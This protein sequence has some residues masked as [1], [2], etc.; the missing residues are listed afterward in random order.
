M[1][2]SMLDADEYLL[3]VQVEITAKTEQVPRNYYYGKLV[4]SQGNEHRAGFAG[5]QPK[6][7]GKPL[8]SGE[9]ATGYINFRLPRRAQGLTLEYAPRIGNSEKARGVAVARELGR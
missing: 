5:C 4:D 2:H 9:T 1:P 7:S 8:R 6:L 3:G